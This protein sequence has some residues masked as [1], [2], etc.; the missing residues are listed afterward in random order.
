MLRAIG[1]SRRQ[2]RRMVRH[3]SVVTALIGA[4]LGIAVGLFLAALATTAL[5]GEGL[6]FARAGRLA[7][8]VHR[9]GRRS[10][11]CSRRSARRAG[12]RGSTC[13]HALQYE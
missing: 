5:S 11:A 12:R 2:V 10:P 1:M 3:E 7:G 6:R 8:R 4:A 13:W 9:G